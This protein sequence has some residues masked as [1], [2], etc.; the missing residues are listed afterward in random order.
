M[1]MQAILISNNVIQNLHL[2]HW[3]NGYSS[4]T[5][6]NLGSML[7]WRLGYIGGSVLQRLLDHPKKD[8]FEITALIRSADKAKLLNTLGVKTVVA[9]LSDLD[10]LT[11]L[12]AASDVVIHTV[13]FVAF[14][15]PPRAQPTV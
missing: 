13:I 6:L 9:S 14:C 8:T 3:R 15:V 10:R 5:V 4:S 2:Y 7:N 1:D 11:E 12:A